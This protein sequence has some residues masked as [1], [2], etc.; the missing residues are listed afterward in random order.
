MRDLH[1]H[2]KRRTICAVIA[3]IC[4]IILAWCVFTATS[5]IVKYN[6]GIKL[7]D[8]LRRDLSRV[9]PSDSN[10]PETSDSI[11]IDY[12]LGVEY[13]RGLYSDTYAYIVI[14][15]TD[16]SYPVM[17]AKNNEFYLNRAYTGE[18]SP[19]GSVFADHRCKDRPEDNYNTVLYAHNLAYG[20]MF[21]A[22]EEMCR[23]REL[24]ENALVRLYTADCEYVYKLVAVYE[25]VS[26]G[27]YFETEFAD[28]AEFA[29][30]KDSVIS[31]SA[32]KTDTQDTDGVMLTLS[33]CTNR[34]QSGRY[35]LHAILVERE[36]CDDEA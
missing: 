30:F 5:E 8:S 23:D 25:T 21:H 31:K 3:V 13:L 19:I 20:G 16:V 9:S 10:S 15:G 12:S 4:A 24:F 17:R 35:A 28:G 34:Q 6:N 26:D 36:T 7:Y 18:Y 27:D 22:V 1:R 32:H 29:G 14:D 33:T 11:A 2:K